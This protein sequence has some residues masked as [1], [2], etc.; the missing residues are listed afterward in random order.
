MW[1]PL[2]AWIRLQIG[3]RTDAASASGSVH[4]KVKDVKDTLATIQKP[5]TSKEIGLFSSSSLG[6]NYVQAGLITGRGMLMELQFSN[7]SGSVFGG[8]LRVTV[9]DT[10]V[11]T[12]P[13]NIAGNTTEYPNSGFYFGGDVSTTGNSYNAMLSFKNSL[14]LEANKTSEYGN[15]QIKWRT[16]L[17]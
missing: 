17:E 3:Q 15:F 6:T 5:R 9:D 2:L 11:Y 7:S 4:A 16:E 8:N 13:V 12:L 14:K 1:G 10:V